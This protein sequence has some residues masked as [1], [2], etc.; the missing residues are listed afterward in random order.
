MYSRYTTSHT[1]VTGLLRTLEQCPQPLYY[2]SLFGFQESVERLLQEGAEVTAKGVFLGDA[3]TAAS[4]QGHSGIVRRMLD[5]GYGPGIRHICYIARSIKRN[6]GET[7]EILLDLGLLNPIPGAKD[8]RIQ[9]TEEV[10][11]AAAG[12]YISGEEVMRVLLDRRGKDLKITIEVEKA[13]AANNRTS[14]T[15]VLRALLDRRG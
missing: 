13:A 9:I 4:I 14:G 11:E 1:F 15:E 10:V 12:N 8:E 2:A 6:A 3:F 7:M 5:R